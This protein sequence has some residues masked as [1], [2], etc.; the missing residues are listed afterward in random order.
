MYLPVSVKIN[1]EITAYNHMR[2]I[3]ILKHTM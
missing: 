3:I 1:V 2:N